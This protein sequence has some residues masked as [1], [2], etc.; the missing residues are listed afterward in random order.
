MTSLGVAKRKLDT[1]CPSPHVGRAI[2]AVLAALAAPTG[3]D[4]GH[5]QDLDALTDVVLEAA[6]HLR[7][8]WCGDAGQADRAPATLRCVMQD[9]LDR[10]PDTPPAS[11][12]AV[13]AHCALDVA[14]LVDDM[15]DPLSDIEGE[16]HPYRSCS[17]G[18]T[19]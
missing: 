3:G 16:H 14:L 13:T 18:R 1:D 11:L 2:M 7:D 17:V 4:S 19:W 9:A 12:E 5:A 15:L 10:L 6:R 8:E